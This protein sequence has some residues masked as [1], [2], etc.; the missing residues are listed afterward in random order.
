MRDLEPRQ[1]NPRKLKSRFYFLQLKQ[2]GIVRGAGLLIFWI[3]AGTVGFVLIEGWSV[4]DA[5]YMTVITLSTVGFQE[6]HPLSASG[7][8]FVIVVILV[9]LTF[10]LY[11]LS[12]LG[13]AI[14]EGE[15]ARTLGRRRMKSELE[16]LTNH[17]VVCGFGR[18]G[19]TVVEGLEQE[20]LPFCVLERDPDLEE[21]FLR[22]RIPYLVG[23]ATDEEAL[24]S[25]GI[26]QA[27]GLFALLPSDAENL[28]V[29]LTVKDPRPDILVVARASDESAEMKLKRGGADHVVSPYRMTGHRMLQAAIRPTTLEFME[30]ATSRQHLELG[31]SEIRVCEG[32]ILEGRSIA[33]AE[34]RARYGV[35]LVAIKKA[36]GEMVFGPGATETITGGD[37]LVGLAKEIDLKTLVEACTS[38]RP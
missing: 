30:L 7:R 19:K 15:L 31:L 36:N 3:L 12:S 23:D 33:E 4:A 6:V 28:Y 18:V 21:E 11:T 9:G 35:V 24:I 32:S 14:V 16:K 17:Y 34:I 8:L 2:L 37:I 1:R 10:V 27:K 26:G 13:K 25:A 5:F 20:G 38:D 22:R 29:T